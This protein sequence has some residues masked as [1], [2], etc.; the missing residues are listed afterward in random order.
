MAVASLKQRAF[1]SFQICQQTRAN[2]ESSPFLL[3]PCHC[4][5]MRRHHPMIER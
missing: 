5:L 2:R 4:A 3:F 1:R